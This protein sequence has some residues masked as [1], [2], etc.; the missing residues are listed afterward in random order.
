MDRPKYPS[1]IPHIIGNEAAERFSYYGMRCILVVFMTRYLMDSSGMLDPMSDVEAR[2][3]Y[4]RFI[5]ANYF[6]PFLGAVVADIWWG[7]YLTIFR[8]SLLYC[9]G[10][11]VLAFWE[12]RM[13]LACGLTFIA[14]GS[15]GIKPCVSAHV[16]DQFS[17]KERVLIEPVFSI[18]YFSINLGAFISTLLTP[19]LL[20]H[21]SPSLAFG[22]PGLFMMLAT[23]VF[24]LGRGRFIAIPPRGWSA[25]K[26][27]LLSTD[28]RSAIVSLTGLC[29]FLSIFWSLFE[30]MGSSWVL[31]ADKMNRVVSVFG[32]YSFTLLP[33]QLQAL[34]PVLIL[35]FIPLF[36][37]VIYPALNRIFALTPIKK[38]S[39]GMFVASCS[40][41]IVG[42]AEAQLLAG[43]SVSIGWQAAAMAVLTAAEVM[44]SITSL[45]FAYTQA[46]PSM[47][48]LLM[49]I[50][51]LSVS[52]G[53]IVASEVNHLIAI[54]GD[55]FLKGELY[56]Y[57]FAILMG[58]TAII[59][60]LV[61]RGYT[62]RLY[63]QSRTAEGLTT[64]DP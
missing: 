2:T 38:I 17:E 33:S 4:H 57:F 18:F 47:K 55:E 36:I 59:F 56:Y 52:L 16:G 12:T 43:N 19:Y 30:Q 53:N 14:I 34:N 51:F 15:G 62:P 49:G 42:I 54:L 26:S 37:K 13:G 20:E 23:W 7:K 45:E 61:Y 44:V 27:D 60:S 63:L 22:I 5:A 58:G 40:F 6:F 9:L 64:V 11:G 50:Y 46:P 25:Y 28:G 10:H 8:L 39:I 21:Y 24:W 1:G 35:I 29:L 32:L 48:S 31:Q 41:I 3:W